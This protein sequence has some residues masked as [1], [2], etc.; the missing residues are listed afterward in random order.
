MKRI[1][2]L[3]LLL[4]CVGNSQTITSIASGNAS[5][6]LI[7]D[8]TC[9]PT[10]S[11]DIVINHTVNLDVNWAITAGG[12]ITVNASGKLLQS[13]LRD[14]LIDGIGSQY[15][16]S[17][18]SAIN[19]IAVL[20][21]GLI[22]N[23]QQFSIT[24][25]LYVGLN[26]NYANDGLMDGLDS[27]MTEGASVNNGTIYTG[28]FLNTGTFGNIGHIAAD[29]MG[30]TGIFSST[31][32]YITATAFGN[33]GTFSMTNQ[34]W[35][36]AT[37]NWWNIGDFTLGSGVQIYAGD[38]FYNGDTLG[39]SASLL[40]NGIIEVIN[41]FYNGW[42]LSGS[43]QI[44][45]G[46]ESY[47]AGAITGTLDICDNTGTDF[48]FNIGTIAGTVLHCQPGCFVGIDEKNIKTTIYPNPTTQFISIESTVDFDGYILTSMT[49]QIVQSGVLNGTEIDL[50]HNE[51][52]MYLLQLINSNQ[53]QNHTI[54]IR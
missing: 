10:T 11:S 13:G 49:G 3:L 24:E 22:D 29:S 19:R 53:T 43:G 28:N 17:G 34:G 5:N 41:N 21:G 38:D 31:S 12:S 42:D 4:P 14:L 44:C 26:S 48:D 45:I 1:L 25:A 32:G 39:G 6:Q 54:I 8:C 35:M 16:N 46:Q 27:L 52:G 50:G 9:F 40:N 37:E 30:N 47:N 20:N 18:Q 33:S 36:D 23:N 51:K 7:W 2:G 15:V